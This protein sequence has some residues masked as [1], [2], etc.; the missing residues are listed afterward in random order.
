MPTAKE[1]VAELLKPANLD[2][3]ADAVLNRDTI[4][5]SFTGNPDNETVTPAT[6]LAVL[7]DRSKPTP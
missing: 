2:K 6:A 1:V 3:I 5:N 4:R 7:G